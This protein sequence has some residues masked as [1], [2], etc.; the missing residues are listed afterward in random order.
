[1]QARLVASALIVA[2]CGFFL[3]T[4][5]LAPE[6]LKKRVSMVSIATF[7]D[8]PIARRTADFLLGSG[9]KDGLFWLRGRDQL[10]RR[11]R[12]IL[13]DAVRRAWSSDVNGSRT[14]YFAGYT[15]ATGS[16]PETWILALSFDEHHSPVPFFVTTHGGYD[17]QGIEDVLNLDGTGPQLLQQDYWGNIS[18]D[19]GY[20]VTTLY[21]QRGCYWYRSDGLHGSHTFPT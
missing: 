5:L 2:T 12:V 8:Y 14:Y 9:G 20:Y 17:K 3:E 15:G 21:E 7:P 10:G 19:P 1:M 4:K 16:A 13:N 18:D 6:E 11:W